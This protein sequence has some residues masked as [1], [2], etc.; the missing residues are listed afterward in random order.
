MSIE[1]LIN[2]V[3]VGDAAKSNNTFNNIMADKMND[4]LNAKKQEIAQ[5][6]YG[7][8]DTPVEEPTGNEEV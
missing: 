7:V 6:M 5:T 8:H 4:A 2:N 1:D 3:K